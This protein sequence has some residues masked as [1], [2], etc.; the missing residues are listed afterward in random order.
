MIDNRTST[1]FPAQKLPK[2]KKTEEW[3]EGCVDSIIARE[4]S[5]SV[6]GSRTRKERMTINYMQ[7]IL[8]GQKNGTT[9]PMIIFILPQQ[10]EIM[11]LY[12]LD[13]LITNY[14]LYI[15]MA[16]RNGAFQLEAR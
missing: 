4:G 5:G 16:L 12:I 6:I 13:H 2:S 8:M 3:K 11:A 14:I 9:Q 7:F 10:L 1:I 15:Q